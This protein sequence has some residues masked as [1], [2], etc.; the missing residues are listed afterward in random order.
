[1]TA[2]GAE[3]FMFWAGDPPQNDDEREIV[4]MERGKAIYRRSFNELTVTD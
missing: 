2:G 3:N 4:V 1:M